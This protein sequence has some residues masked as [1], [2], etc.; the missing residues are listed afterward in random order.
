[1]VKTDQM[2]RTTAQKVEAV[3]ADTSTIAPDSAVASCADASEIDDKCEQLMDAGLLDDDPELTEAAAM[4][5]LSAM[6]AVE[7][8][9]AAQAEPVVISPEASQPRLAR[10]E[11]EIP[12]GQRSPLP[13]DAVGATPVVAVADASAEA[14]LVVEGE[15]DLEP[16][17]DDSV[18]IPGAL[19][20]SADMQGRFTEL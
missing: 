19:T 15:K 2:A 3:L 10:S 5:H 4:A 1:M 14:L 17:D 9:A 12:P 8:L 13:A 6:S 11:S 18:N 16:Y 7:K 20:V